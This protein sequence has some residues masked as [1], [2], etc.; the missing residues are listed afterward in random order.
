VQRG[1]DRSW[2]QPG[3]NIKA[4]GYDMVADPRP[5]AADP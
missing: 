1:G 5:K 3:P 2:T 4:L